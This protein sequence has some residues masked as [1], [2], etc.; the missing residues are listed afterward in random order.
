MSYTL[1]GFIIYLIIVFIVGFITYKNNESHDDFFIGGRKLNP[2][3]VAF[4]ERASG[5][6]A[7]LLLGLPGAALAGG[8][9]QSWTAAGCVLGIIF[10][11]FVI[12]KG[13]RIE[14]E[15]LNAITLP[16]FFAERF[17]EQGKIIRVLATMIIIFFFTFYLA[18][19]F[20]GAGKVLF[21]TFGIPHIWGIVIGVVVIVFYTMMGGF[22]AVA[23]TDLIQGIIMIGALVILP[24]FGFIELAKQGTSFSH[25]IGAEGTHFN[26]FVENKTGWAAAAV[27]IS[28]LS[29]GL[30]YMGQPHL[31]TRFMSIKSADKIKTSRI[32]AIAWAI[33]AFAGAMLIG[34]IGLALYGKGYYVD[35][36]E[37]MP[38]LATTLLPTWLAGIFISG[39]IAA[40]MSTADSQLLVIT[41]SVIEDFY[42]KTL[43]MD[44]T[45]KRLLFLSR[46]I[47]IVVGAIGFIIAISSENLIYELVSYAWAGLGSSFG[48]ALLLILFWK[49]VTSQ[50]V[51]AG[52]LTG[53]ISTIIWSNIDALE[54]IISVRFVSFV[55][56][57]TAIFIVSKIT[58]RK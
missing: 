15:K 37:I 19:Q 21:V 8:F 48:P 51:I 20:N 33:P 55:F 13:L 3:V 49:K 54:N 17:G 42:H 2:W 5:E 11:W 57:I 45:E 6:S 35:V 36:E 58:Y 43:G 46:V 31:L 12:A 1:L 22:F 26:S 41:S 47:T 4:S 39:A 23:W 44:V 7:W 14:S 32:I 34:L 29:W 25:A 53:S 50:G 56:A 16:N 30:G 9:M 24:I 18:A 27:I 28:G 10:Y 40:M 52:M 38:H